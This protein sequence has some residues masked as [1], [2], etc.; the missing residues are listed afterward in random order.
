[1]SHQ[2]DNTIFGQP[3]SPAARQ[4]GDDILP[5]AR[6]G[7]CD[8]RLRTRLRQVIGGFLGV[9]LIWSAGQK[10]V[11]GSGVQETLGYAL[12]I[13]M[14]DSP[15]DTLASTDALASPAAESGGIGTASLAGWG[16]RG[17]I[18]L[19]AGLGGLLIFGAG[20]SRF[21]AAA[22]LFGAFS[23]FVAFLLMSDAEVGCGCGLSTSNDPVEAS[24]LF[25][26]GGLFTVA[27]VGLGTYLRSWPKPGALLVLFSRRL[28]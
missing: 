24:A 16:A 18:V 22:V 13:V 2:P 15:T 1:M 25:R 20:G 5:V 19:E 11:D 3:G 9:L 27:L 8:G 10:A 14:S 17:L 26:T 12:Q 4:P 23:V 6:P 28:A 7:Y 21:V